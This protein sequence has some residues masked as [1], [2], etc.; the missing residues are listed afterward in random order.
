MALSD[1]LY[2]LFIAGD[3]YRAF[4]GPS[5]T[6]SFGTMTARPSFRPKALGEGVVGD[7]YFRIKLV[8]MRLE[9]NRKAWQG[10]T[11]ALQTV[12]TV[13]LDGKPVEFASTIGPT[14]FADLGNG[15]FRMQGYHGVRLNDW[16]PFNGGGVKLVTGLLAVPNGDGLGTAIEILSSMSKLIA[17]PALSTVTG[18]AAKVAEGAE[19]LLQTRKQTGI[20][21][22][23][24]EM[25]DHEVAPQYLLAV[26]LEAPVDAIEAFS[27]VDKELLLDNK[28]I[29]DVAYVLLEVEVTQSIAKRWETIPTINKPF[30]AAVTE[31]HSRGEKSASALQLAAM[32]V[33][34]NSPDLSIRDRD[35]VVALMESRWEMELKRK[36]PPP[37]RTKPRVSEAQKQKQKYLNNSALD[38]VAKDAFRFESQM[39]DDAFSRVRSMID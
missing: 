14:A 13:Q 27:Y 32:D 39:A 10:L 37:R 16:I 6:M 5:S 35:R 31:L 34:R 36:S 30:Q 26:G 2:Q 23:N 17:V 25:F 7:R 8:D 29:R 12:L 33:A 11:P 9:S 4:I 18:I 15:N 24:V 1:F 20:L 28:P 3:P 38:Q 22:L 21:G 19:K